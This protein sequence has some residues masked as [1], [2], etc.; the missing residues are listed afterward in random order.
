M[1]RYLKRITI[2][3][4]FTINSH[5]TDDVRQVSSDNLFIIL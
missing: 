2:F 3:N 4:R 5:L 1:P